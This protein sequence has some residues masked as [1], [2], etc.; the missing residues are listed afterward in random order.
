[1]STSTTGLEVAI[2]GMACRFPGATTIEQFWLN[3]LEGHESVSFFSDEELREAGVDPDLL[4]APNYVRASSVLDAIDLFDAAFFGLSPREASLTDPQHRLFLE[5]AW[6]ALEAAGYDPAQYTGSIGVF[7]GVG[8]NSYLISQIQLHQHL[9]GSAEEYQMLIGNDKDFL[10]TRVAYKFGLRGPAV[11]IQ[12]ACSTA[13]VATHLACQSLLSGESDIA[14]AGGV[15]IHV[16]QKSGYLSQQGSIISPDGH[17]RPFDARAQGTVVGSGAGV[18]LLKRLEDALSDGDYLYAVIKGSAMNNDGSQKVGYTAPGIEGQSRVIRA[19]HRMAEVDP[20]TISYIEAHGTGTPLGDPIEIAALTQAF[21]VCTYQ[22][23]FCAIGSVKSNIGHLD[24]AAGIAGLIKTALALKHR[25]LPPSINFE[26]PNPGID[27]TQ[28][29]FYVNTRLSPWHSDGGPRRAGVS[30]FGIGGT[31]A[32]VVLEEA[33][34]GSPSAPLRSLHLLTLSAR[35]A[36]ALDTLTAHLAAHLEQHPE[37]A[38]PDI[39]YTLHIGRT[40]YAH[41]RV[42]V[43]KERDDALI[44]LAASDTSLTGYSERNQRPIV[45]LFPGQGAQYMQMAHGLYQSEMVFRERV[46]YCSEV[47]RPHLGL[48]LRAILYATAE[49]TE[50]AMQRLEQTALTQPALFVIEYALA[51]LWMSWDV[52]PT[53]MIGHS[54]G[55]FVAACLAGVM[56]LEDA[57][58]LVAVRGRLMQRLPPGLMLAV[59]LPAEELQALPAEGISLAAVN[60]PASS[61]VAGPIPAVEQFEQVLA[62]RNVPYRRLRTS[63]AFHSHMM[64]PAQ[65]DFVAY[66][67][68]VVL[69]PPRLAYLSNVTGDWITAREATDPSY[70]AGHLRQTVHFNRG[71]ELLL[72]EPDRL[73]LEVGP[74]Q[75]L[76]SHVNRHPHKGAAHLALASLRHRDDTQS[77]E[78]HLLQTLGRLWL[79]GATID[80]KRFHEHEQLRRVPLPTYPFERQRYWVESHSSTPSHL[81]LERLQGEASTHLDSPPESSVHSN[82]SSP[83]VAPRNQIEETVA[84]VWQRV[85]GIPAPGIHDNF[86]ELGGDSLLGL[87]LLSRLTVATGIELPPDSLLRAPTIATQAA[88]LYQQNGTSLEQLAHRRDTNAETDMSLLVRLKPGG[89][90][91]PLFLVHPVGGGVYIYQHLARHLGN[92]RPIYAIQARGFDGRAEPLSS[93]EAMAQL[94]I[95][96]IRRVQPEGDYLLAGMSF[97]GVVSFEMA[98]QLRAIGQQVALLALFDTPDLAYIAGQMT[99]DAVILASMFGAGADLPALIVALRQ[100]EPEA[101]LRYCLEQ[102]QLKHSLPPD[103]NLSTFRHLFFLLKTHI[104][105]LQRYQPR[106]YSGEVL[107]FRAAVRDLFNPPYPERYWAPWTPEGITI[108]EVPGD[109]ASMHAPPH[110]QYLAAKLQ[111]YLDRDKEALAGT[112]CLVAYI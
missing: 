110:V 26:T 69:R 98:Q 72:Q 51:S 108:H 7:A 107:Y 57:L 105:A 87:M 64:E 109:H 40:V 97:G 18:V 100:L 9:S 70:W 53:A 13:L 95:E 66:V 80:W 78:A 38:L 33:P 15:S 27:F 101:Q 88:L 56:S 37:H 32:H 85:L 14:L 54:I 4:A 92:D 23:Q 42:V 71:I 39:A 63:H 112:C 65:N 81:S 36:T 82:T 74:G 49:Q 106:P 19:A 61:V 103:C 60:A 104:G 21:G 44:A 76:S 86:F 6:E 48:D 25:Q 46:D 10:A 34:E 68:R 79:A 47:L 43:C 41:R 59:A 12:T 24:A 52:H 58:E 75:T 45:F 20:E 5:C 62:S 1:M 73:F 99:D 67:R 102:P 2:I 84:Q 8:F 91:R 94:Y 16:P 28:S 22:K 35:T 93:I 50:T 55:E 11:T 31:N 89:T 30:A 3:L 83:S 77:D 29:P 90:K 111:R 96:I 17:C